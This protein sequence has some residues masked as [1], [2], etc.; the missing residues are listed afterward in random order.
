MQ[1]H[2]MRASPS[3]GEVFQTFR[4]SVPFDGCAIILSWKT[5]SVVYTADCRMRED[6]AS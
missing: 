3:V 4:A 5:K 6:V 1:Q 2:R